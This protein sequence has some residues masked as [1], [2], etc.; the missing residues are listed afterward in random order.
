MSPSFRRKGLLPPIERSNN[1]FVQ[2]KYGDTT[3]EINKISKAT[4]PLMEGN[5]LVYLKGSLVPAPRLNTVN[6]IH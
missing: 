3:S 1:F 4:N 5:K 2:P 6:R